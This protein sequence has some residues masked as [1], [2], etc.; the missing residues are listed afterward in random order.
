MVNVNLPIRLAY[1]KAVKDVDD[2]INTL[3]NPQYIAVLRRRYL[4]DERW[5]VIALEL[6]YSLRNVHR[7]HHE[8]IDMLAQQNTDN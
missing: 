4:G 3:D 7:L 2:L 5:E 1:L 8:A 6:G